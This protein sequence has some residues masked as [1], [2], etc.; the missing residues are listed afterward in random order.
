[1]KFSAFG[2]IL[3]IGLFFFSACRITNYTPNSHLGRSLLNVEGKKVLVL[4]VVS[5]LKNSQEGEYAH[6]LLEYLQRCPKTEVLD[7]DGFYNEYQI[8]FAVAETLDDQLAL[9]NQYTNVDILLLP[10]ARIEASEISVL[11]ADET[12]IGLARNAAVAGIE[13]YDIKNMQLLKYNEYFGQ[14]EN[15]GE[16]DFDLEFYQSANKIVRKCYDRSLSDFLKYV[17]CFDQ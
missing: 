5:N 3:L 8:G 15:T 10:Y 4:P 7:M 9:L 6:K 17:S 11:D 16:S 12:T 2:N 13:A 1:M 14:V